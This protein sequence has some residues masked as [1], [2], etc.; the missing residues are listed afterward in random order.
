LI[1]YGQGSVAQ[2]GE[3]GTALGECLATPSSGVDPARRAA[4]VP[5][6]LQGSQKVAGGAL[7]QAEVCRACPRTYSRALNALV[8][9]L[10]MKPDP[11]NIH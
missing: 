4:Q 10:I 5:A 9:D 8:T 3:T 2:S 6:I 11:G 1:H 7:L